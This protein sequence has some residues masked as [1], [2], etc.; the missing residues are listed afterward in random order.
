MPTT[1]TTT[2]VQT[3]ALQS[4]SITNQAGTGSPTFV[5]GVKNA[6]GSVASPSV[7][8]LNSPTTGLFRKAADSLG[9]SAAGVEVGS[10]TSA[11]AWTLG[12]AN[13]SAKNLT[14][15]GTVQ[16]QGVGL[17]ATSIG[18]WSGNSWSAVGLNT[19]FNNSNQT[20]T[21]T[22][23]GPSSAFLTNNYNT[24]NIAL[25]FL[26]AGPGTAGATITPVGAGYIDTQGIWTNTSSPVYQARGTNSGYALAAGTV[27]KFQ[28][29]GGFSQST[30]TG[31]VSQ[32]TSPASG[33]YLV[34]I[35][36]S[37]SAATTAASFIDVK[38]NGVSVN[39]ISQF[40]SGTSLIQ[41]TIPI[42]VNQTDVVT[43]V[44]STASGGIVSDN[45]ADC[46]VSFAKIA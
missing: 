37:L 38:I 35:S 29:A 7:T 12:P 6:D 9:I 26:V 46:Y 42:K 13:S 23:T 11:G 44:N 31:T 14:V 28:A 5:N 41:G 27:I 25:Q 20:L 8:F 45:V 18:P 3:P 4:D 16:T 1:I 17:G 21:Y 32:Y 15:N 39:R 40:A 33:I 43:L 30:G 24:S 22:Q 10:F 36:L 34:M 2:L 19:T